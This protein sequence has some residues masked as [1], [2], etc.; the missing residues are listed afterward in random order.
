LRDLGA[1]RVF[2]LAARGERLRG[3]RDALGAIGEAYGESPAWLAIPVERFARSAS[4]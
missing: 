4:T 2:A 3:E 1:T